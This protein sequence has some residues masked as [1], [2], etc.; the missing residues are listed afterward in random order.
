M[1][2][3]ADLTPPPGID[4]DEFLRLLS[5]AAGAEAAAVPQADPRETGDQLANVHQGSKA[6]TQA[7]VEEL[8]GAAV[9]F[10]PS[11]AA[12]PRAPFVHGGEV[13]DEAAPASADLVEETSGPAEMAGA[14]RQRASH[15]GDSG[16]SIGAQPAETGRRGSSQ[17]PADAEHPAAATVP[18][19]SDRAASPAAAGDES[20]TAATPDLPAA[21]SHDAGPQAATNSAPSDI[22][23]AGG[24]VQENAGAGTVVATL[25]AVDADAGDSFT[26]TLV[27]PS[28]LF[29]IVGNQLV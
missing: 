14:V 18:E 7:Q 29:E 3:T 12:V 13:A 15:Q 10:R 22:T 9:A 6:V 19:A 4:L 28:N 20:V 26:Y 11:E 17:L 23:V 5:R 25:N 1:S 2:D 16:V 27:Q 24:S 8:P 21:P